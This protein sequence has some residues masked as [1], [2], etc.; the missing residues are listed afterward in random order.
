MSRL[1]QREWWATYQFSNGGG[2][3]TTGQPIFAN[4]KVE[5]RKKAYDSAGENEIL[6]SVEPIEEGPTQ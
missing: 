1:P 4:S 3:Y 5:A 6:I 2:V